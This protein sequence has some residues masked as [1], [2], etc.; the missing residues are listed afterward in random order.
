VK[1]YH[2]L[3]QLN[4]NEAAQSEKSETKWPCVVQCMIKIITADG[5]NYINCRRMQSSEMRRRVALVKTHVSEERVSSI[6][7]QTKISQLALTL[8]VTSN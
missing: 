6:I 7:S 3:L 8:S 5:P 2:K 1:K 4:R